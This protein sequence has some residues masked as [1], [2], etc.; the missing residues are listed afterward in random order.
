[1]PLPL[2]A[3]N[4]LYYAAIW[5]MITFC[6]AHP[7]AALL[8]AAAHALA[9]LAP[10][11]ALLWGRLSRAVV[12]RGA[13]DWVRG[14]Y[15]VGYA[16]K[17]EDGAFDAAAAQR[18]LRRQLGEDGE[19]VQAAALAADRPGFDQVK[20][21]V[22]DAVKH[23]GFDQ[24]KPVIDAG[25]FD[26]VKPAA[27]AG[28]E[29][30]DSACMPGQTLRVTAKATTASS[31]EATDD[32]GSSGTSS[33]TSSSANGTSGVALE[34][35]SSS[36]ED[37]GSG[38]QPPSDAS[39]LAASHDGIAN[40]ITNTCGI[41]NIDDSSIPGAAQRPF[42][43]C[44]HPQGYFARGAFHTFAAVG[45][46]SPVAA[47][48]GVKFAVGRWPMRVPVLQQALLVMGCTE[49]S[50]GNLRA[51]LMS[52]GKVG[53]CWGKALAEDHHHH[54]PLINLSISPPASHRG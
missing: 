2:M 3:L 10:A 40:G 33:S 4:L 18:A 47:L 51:L 39:F 45:R 25:T 12:R 48:P 11:A 13:W 8:V 38:S 30:F 7:R 37:N 21:P 15:G 29:F 41:T 54:L 9:P 46:R 20:H 53:G 23:A 44:Y 16:A 36:W 24:V 27:V 17:G 34:S 6:F 35:R 50:F 1:M 32:G 19:E 14:L 28:T 49:A 42:I 31:S 52:K 43:F 26:P 22:F 5:A